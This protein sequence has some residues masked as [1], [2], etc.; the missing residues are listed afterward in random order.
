LGLNSGLGDVGN[1]A[2]KI[3]AVHQGWG[4]SSLLDS[5][6]ADRR[7]VALVNA[8]QSVKNGQQ[9]FTLLKTLGTTDPDLSAAKANLFR[10]ITDPATRPDV[11]KGIEAQREHF[12]NL[13]LHIGYIYGDNDIPAS[14]SLYKASYRAGARLPHAWLS[15]RPETG[16]NLPPIDSSY[17]SELSP[18]Q[19]AAKRYSTLDLCA[20]DS[21]TLIADRTFQ[22]RWTQVL[23][24][25]KA[26]LPKGSSALKINLVLL[27]THFKLVPDMRAEE[28]LKGMQI[29]SGGALLVRPDQHILNAFARDTSADQVLKELIEHIGL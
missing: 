3:A 16:Q 23:T 24:T 12:D 18:E 2:Y 20:F 13:C 17:V 27:G 4:S 14:A 29:R 19:I 15:G 1:L 22:E 11:L 6:Q 28:W 26:K 5:Y 7:Q 9:I 25:L 21:F 10:T 8:K